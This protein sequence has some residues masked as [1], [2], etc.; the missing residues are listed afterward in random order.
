MV[1]RPQDHEL[2]VRTVQG[3]RDQQDRRPGRVNDFRCSA[4]NLTGI[5]DRFFFLVLYLHVFTRSPNRS[6]SRP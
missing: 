5:T 3:L 6:V 4:G 1:D 2:H